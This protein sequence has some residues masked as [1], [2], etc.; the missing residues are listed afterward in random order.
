MLLLEDY[1]EY[2]NLTGVFIIVG[3]VA[4]IIIISLIVF[5]CVRK[6]KK[7]GEDISLVNKNFTEDK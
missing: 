7:R 2:L 1:V 6:H 5:F 4:A 3:V